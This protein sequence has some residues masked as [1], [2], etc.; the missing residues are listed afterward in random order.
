M[1]SSLK[2]HLICVLFLCYGLLQAAS[3]SSQIQTSEQKARPEFSLQKLVMRSGDYVPATNSYLTAQREYTPY[4]VYQHLKGIKFKHQ[5]SDFDAEYIADFT[6]PTGYCYGNTPYECN[7]PKIVRLMTYL[8][9]QG[10][11]AFD[12]NFYKISAALLR[13]RWLDAR[14]RAAE[15]RRIECNVPT[16]SSRNYSYGQPPLLSEIDPNKL[17][18]GIIVL[19]FYQQ[20]KAKLPKPDFFSSCD[21]I[22]LPED[23]LDSTTIKEKLR[24]LLSTVQLRLGHFAFPLKPGI[25]DWHEAEQELHHDIQQIFQADSTVWEKIAA[26][27]AMFH[28][29]PHVKKYQNL[30]PITHKHRPTV[31]SFWNIYYGQRYDEMNV[32]PYSPINGVLPEIFAK[33][34]FNAL[35]ALM[36]TGSCHVQV[37]TF[38]FNDI[39][40]Q[41]FL[42]ILEYVS[43]DRSWHA[44]DRAVTNIETFLYKQVIKLFADSIIDVTLSGG[45]KGFL[46]DLY[47]I[48]KRAET[49]DAT[50]VHYRHCSQR[51]LN[52]LPEEELKRVKHALLQSLGGDEAAIASIDT[53]TDE[54]QAYY[55]VRAAECDEVVSELPV[56]LLMYKNNVQPSCL[57]QEFDGYPHCNYEPFVW[58]FCFLTP[59]HQKEF[60]MRMWDKRKIPLE[61][62]TFLQAHKCPDTCLPVCKRFM[63]IYRHIVY[64]IEHDFDHVDWHDINMLSS[65]R[66]INL[67]PEMEAELDGM[68][69]R[70]MQRM[71][72]RYKAVLQALHADVH[73]GKANQLCT[74]EQL[75]AHIDTLDITNC[76]TLYRLLYG[77]Q[78]GA[79][80]PITSKACEIGWHRW[81]QFELSIP[82]EMRSYVLLHA[83]MQHE[84]I[85]RLEQRIEQ[86]QAATQPVNA[87]VQVAIVEQQP[88]VQQPEVTDVQHFMQQYGV[89][90]LRYVVPFLRIYFGI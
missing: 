63:D 9:D 58:H 46:L 37:P 19:F 59:Q 53:T 47:N 55:K 15:Q 74:K 84:I 33:E 78:N 56:Y 73:G 54:M 89:P 20:F 14:F 44:T 1:N 90:V 71:Y 68:R 28:G 61:V 39:P 8:G 36:P 6:F 77:R 32:K 86:L 16:T 22:K 30:A 52:A 49:L 5:I 79:M 4:E 62:E 76:Q 38:T 43:A 45:N 7:I 40:K 69:K 17:P 48:I 34:V 88:A 72:P 51:L 41:K 31:P 2:R 11:L 85:Q 87:D 24:R 3:S 21:R 50:K 27:R 26:L 57:R 13:A 75:F 18:D 12:D 83:G 42:N 81:L 64:G 10:I 25:A 67:L 70:I 80:R 65:K 23:E 66:R 82:I 60:L 29:S 35:S